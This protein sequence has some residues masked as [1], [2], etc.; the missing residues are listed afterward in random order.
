MHRIL[1]FLPALLLAAVDAS[2]SSPITYQGH[3]QQSGT[4]Y[5][6]NAD[7]EF[8]LFDQLTGGSQFG[9]TISLTDWPVIGGLFQAELDFGSGVFGSDPRYLEVSVDGSPLSPRQLIQPA[10]VAHFALDGNPGPEGPQGPEGP[11]GP[12]GPQGPSGIVTSA[13]AYG[14]GADPTTSLQFL[15]EPV[16]INVSS[17][18]VVHVTSHKAFGSI[19]AAGA[20]NLNLYICYRSVGAILQSVGGGIWGL[21]VAQNTRQIFGLSATIQ[22]LDG[23]Y[24]VGLCGLAETGAANWN[25]NDWGY[26]TALV[27]TE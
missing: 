12:I 14:Y 18:Q 25:Y 23:A 26:T 8:R 19:V 13:F 20:S 24:Q 6:G 11:I 15:V 10:P 4:R 2:A 22:A 16:S 27:Y 1:I 21:R 7:L 3:L 5:T 17:G 9:P